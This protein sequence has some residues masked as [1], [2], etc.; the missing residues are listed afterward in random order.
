MDRA[1]KYESV[2]VKALK[3]PKVKAAIKGKE[4]VRIIYVP[5]KLINIV[6]KK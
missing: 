6:T 2:I 5:N 3:S 4:I 1:L